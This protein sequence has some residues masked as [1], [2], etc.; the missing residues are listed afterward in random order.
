MKTYNPAILN[1][2]YAIKVKYPE[3]VEQSGL[4]YCANASIVLKEELAKIG[5]EGK[6]LYGKYLKDNKAGQ[7]AKAHF[8]NLIKHFPISKNFHG[9]V[10]SSFVKNGNKVSDKGGH[11]G[12]LVGSDIYDVTSAQFGLPIAYPLDQFLGMWADAHVVDITLKPHRTEWSQK[13]LYSYQV[14]DTGAVALEGYGAAMGFE[15][16]G[17]D[18]T[19]KLDFHKWFSIQS[20]QVQSNCRIVSS[21]E[22]GQDYMLHIDKNTPAK[23]TPMFSEHAG[24]EEDKTLPRITVAPNLFGCVIGYARCEPDFLFHAYDTSPDFKKDKFRGGYEICQLNFTHCLK[25]SDVMVSNASESD[26]HWLVNYNR[27]TREYLPTKIGKC[28]ISEI[29]YLASSDA[30][31]VTT[32]TLYVELYGRDGIYF[33]KNIKLY[34]G[35]YRVTLTIDKK[36]DWGNINNEKGISV[37]KI[38]AGEYA[39]AKGLSAAMLS[40]ESITTPKYLNW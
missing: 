33:S 15:E 25:P 36:A 5:I 34:K 40:M 14:K 21:D 1:I 8:S 31:P 16:S 9:R 4:G 13:V 12:V 11:V 20:K 18:D 37:F 10:K 17:L 23:F 19:D 26:E 38:S 28:F 32:Y 6:L 30:A 24:R 29:K 2:I 3:F 39:S 35:F 27:E 22:L 7:E